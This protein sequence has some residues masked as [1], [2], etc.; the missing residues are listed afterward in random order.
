MPSI[1]VCGICNLED[2]E[3]AVELGAEYIGFIFAESARQVSAADAR[4]IKRKLKG[5]IKFVGVFRNQDPRFIN[6]TAEVL[7]L[8]FVQLHGDESPEYCRQ[9]H[10]PIIKAIELIPTSNHQKAPSLSDVERH[11]GVEKDAK[12]AEQLARLKD[13][14]VHAFL[15]DRPKSLAGDTQWLEKIISEYATQLQD[16][17]PFFIAGGLNAQNV[18]LACKLHPFG[19]DI[20]SGVEAEPGKKDHKKLE[21]FFQAVQGA[22][23]C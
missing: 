12:S 13:Y 14:G 8:D 1:K 18:Q 19:I 3:K 4:Q 2:A 23:A 10:K 16:W 17:Q 21:E 20:A 6:D 9:I 11:Q 5:E 7:G 15:F 22:T